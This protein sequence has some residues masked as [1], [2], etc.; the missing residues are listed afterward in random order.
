MM[1]AIVICGSDLAKRACHTAFAL[2]HN[3]QTE[4]DRSRGRGMKRQNEKAPSLSRFSDHPGGLT[5]RLIRPD[6]RIDKSRCSD[7]PALTGS[8]PRSSFAR[9]LPKGRK[10]SGGVRGGLKKR[11]FYGIASISPCSCV[12]P[13]ASGKAERRPPL[14][15]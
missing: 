10:N 15:D 6:K 8:P 1:R 12:P 9:L 14:G 5:E 13:V 11:Q 7:H 4:R 2:H 3:C